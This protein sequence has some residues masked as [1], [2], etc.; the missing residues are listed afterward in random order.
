MAASRKADPDYGQISGLV[1]KVLITEF[2]V[3]TAR[4][5]LNQSDQFIGSYFFG[6]AGIDLAT[7]RGL[8]NTYIANLT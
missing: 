4:A 7:L 2:K 5:D 3:A 6:T 8:I 1:P